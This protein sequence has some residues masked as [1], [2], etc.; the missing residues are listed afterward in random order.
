MPD[1]RTRY[2]GL[3]LETPIVVASSGLTETVEK[4][5]LCQEHGAGAVVVKSYAEEEVMRTS[6]TPRYRILR[7]RLGGEGSVTFISY[8]QASKFDIERYAQEVADAKAKLR[9]KVIP[10][11]LC[12]TDEGWVKAAQLLEEA[13][14]DA[15][16]INT[17]CP[18][19]SITFRGKRV[20]ETIF[21]TVRLI[22]EAV[23][24]PLVVKVSS[25]LT[26]PIGV[27][28]EVERIGVQGVTI[29]NRM[30]AL[31]VDVHTEEIEMPGGYAGHGGPWAIQYPLRWISQI[32]PEVKLDIAAS[33]G[34]S[35]WED[36]V[37]YIPVSYT[38]LTLPTKA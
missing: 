8:E 17:S 30:T 23:S 25:M 3:E 37:R 24:L 7:R 33:G 22:R 9:I 20:E 31:D 21:R 18:H 29:F 26:S 12:V 5:R 15:L 34:V 28:K 32:Y 6:P 27:V 13:G 4:M 38:H 14:A 35:C 2:V 19:G 1:L 16:E 36:V 11:I 10:S